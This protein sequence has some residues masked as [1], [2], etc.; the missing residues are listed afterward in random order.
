MIIVEFTVKINLLMDEWWLNHKI[1]FDLRIYTNSF[2]CKM[3]SK[4]DT[5]EWNEF[6]KSSEKSKEYIFLITTIINTLQNT[7]KFAKL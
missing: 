5:I 2:N 1:E 6:I 3:H 4:L 7:K